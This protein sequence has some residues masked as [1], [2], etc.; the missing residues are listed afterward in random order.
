MLIVLWNRCGTYEVKH[1]TGKAQGCTAA[2]GFVAL[3]SWEAVDAFITRR[4]R[5]GMVAKVTYG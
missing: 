3:E 2:E 5:S 1:V 4:K